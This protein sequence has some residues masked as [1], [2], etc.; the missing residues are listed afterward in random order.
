M[1]LFNHVVALISICSG[2]KMGH[3]LMNR[4][5][6]AA[7]WFYYKFTSFFCILVTRWPRT[8]WVSLKQERNEYSFLLYRLNH[9]DPLILICSDCN[10]GHV[11]MKKGLSSAL[12]FYFK[13]TSVFFQ[14]LQLNDQVETPITLKLGKI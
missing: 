9:G 6:S 12:T 2:F 1:Q 10:M 5:L 7:T 13:R 11:L 8:R 14:F 4:G 3:V